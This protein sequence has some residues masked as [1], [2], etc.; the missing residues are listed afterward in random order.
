MVLISDA[1]NPA[2]PAQQVRERR[3][4]NGQM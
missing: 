3:M 1:L 2:H 4:G